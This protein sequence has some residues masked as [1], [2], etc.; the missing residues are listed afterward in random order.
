MEA[1]TPEQ[2]ER[3]TQLAREALAPHAR[4]RGVALGAAAWRVLAFKPR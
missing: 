2:R 4:E 1:A 3:A